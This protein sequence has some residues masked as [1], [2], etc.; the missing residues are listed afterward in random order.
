MFVVH[1]VTDMTIT[2]TDLPDV[3]RGGCHR[4]NLVVGFKSRKL[5]LI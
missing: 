4:S 5:G 1:I 2:S 3:Y